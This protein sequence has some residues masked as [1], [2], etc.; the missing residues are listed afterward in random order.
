ML[1]EINVNPSII[2][3]IGSYLTLKT[4]KTFF[5]FDLFKEIL[6]LLTREESNNINMNNKYKDNFTD[7]LFTLFSYPNDYITKTALITFIKE[8]KP[9]ITQ[10]Q[11]NSILEKMQIKKHIT[12]EKFAEIVDYV[13]KELIE[14]LE[15]ISYFRYIFFNTKLEDHSLEKNCIELLLKGNTLHEYI[16]ERLQY[17]KIFYI[18]DK[19]FY[20]KWDDFMNL[21]E[22]EQKRFDLKGLRMTT[23]K[24]SDKN[25]KLL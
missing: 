23:N 11:I 19:E 5:N 12:K 14:S 2:R 6:T 17:D 10:N 18:I 21:P 1:N 7:G 24:I 15:H 20:V 8:N 16:I 4:K 25:G 9:E 13:I 3:I 22:E